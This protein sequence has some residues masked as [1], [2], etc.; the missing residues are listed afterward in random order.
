MEACGSPLGPCCMEACGSPLGPCCMAPMGFHKKTLSLRNLFTSKS[1]NFQILLLRNMFTPKST[2]PNSLTS[3]SIPFKICW[4]PNPKSFCFKMCSLPNPLTSEICSL[5]NPL[6]VH[7]QIHS[8]RNLFTSNPLTSN[9][10]FCSN[11]CCCVSKSPELRYTVPS[12]D[13][14]HPVSR[15]YIAGSCPRFMPSKGGLMLTYI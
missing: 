7:F 8:L 1:T 13:S 10:I 12:R 2:L 9:L 14:I 4:L 6:F 3:K 15:H 11:C 5:P